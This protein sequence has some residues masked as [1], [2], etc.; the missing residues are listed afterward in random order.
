MLREVHPG[1][2]K[3]RLDELYSCLFLLC[4]ELIQHIPHPEY[5][6]T[7][8]T[9]DQKARKVL[10]EWISSQETRAKADSDGTNPILYRLEVLL[11]LYLKK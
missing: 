1:H 2:A 3:E 10:N 4:R 6:D 9:K 11:R 8:M 5:R 7:R